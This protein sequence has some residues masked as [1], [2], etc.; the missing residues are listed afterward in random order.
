MLI[1][2]NA[3]KVEGYLRPVDLDCGELFAFLDDEGVFMRVDDC[4]VNLDE[5]NLMDLYDYEEKPI[6]RLCGELIIKE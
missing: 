6:K 4:I 2:K 1:I 3:P 5:G